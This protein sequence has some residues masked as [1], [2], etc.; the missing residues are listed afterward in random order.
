MGRARTSERT[1][2]G[3]LRRRRAGGFTLLELLLALSL[4]ILIMG[5]VFGFYRNILRTREEGSQVAKEVMLTRALLEGLA[6]EIRHASDIVPGDGRGFRGTRDSITILR[7]H[8]PDMG[9]AYTEYDG[10]DADLPPGQKDLGRITYSLAKSEDEELVDEEGDPLVFG[11]FRS[12]QTAFDP[13]P[14]FVVVDDETGEE[15]EESLEPRQRVFGELLAP[16][17]KYLEFRYFDGAKWRDRWQVAYEGPAVGG[18]VSEEEEVDIDRPA[19]SRN[20]LGG[21]GY[22]LPQAVRI[23]IGREPLDPEEKERL[24]AEAEGMVDEYEELEYYPGRYTIIVYLRQADPSLLS[25]RKHGLENQPDDL[26]GGGG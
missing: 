3:R 24:E 17:I 16:E 22:A 25:S 18:E 2:G 15:A 7:Y 10:V 13:N 19:S 21:V 1:R 5:I 20:G 9:R 12:E 6:K 23:T 26:F 11:L 8:I 4:M 14:S